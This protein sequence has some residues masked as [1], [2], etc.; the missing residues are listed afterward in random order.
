MGEGGLGFFHGAR[1]VLSRFR[2]QGSDD[3]IYFSWLAPNLE[4]T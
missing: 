1:L 3:D 4:E 2:R